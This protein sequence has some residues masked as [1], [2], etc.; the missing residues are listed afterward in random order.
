MPS[1]TRGAIEV[2]MQG[3]FLKSEAAN[4]SLDPGC[5]TIYTIQGY[6]QAALIKNAYNCNPSEGYEK[7]HTK[8]R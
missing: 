3:N 8:F 6:Q 7:S 5:E 1:D 4:D 2:M